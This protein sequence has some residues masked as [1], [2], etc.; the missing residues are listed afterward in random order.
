MNFLEARNAKNHRMAVTVTRKH[1]KRAVARN[2]YRRGLYDALLSFLKVV[3]CQSPVPLSRGR[4][5]QMEHR[6]YG[7]GGAE[8]RGGGL[9]SASVSKP[10][11]ATLDKYSL[12]RVTGAIVKNPSTGEM[13]KG[14]SSNQVPSTKMYL[15]VF[16]LKKGLKLTEKK[17]SDA[18][19]NDA[20]KLFEKA[21]QPQIKN[22]Q[23]PRSL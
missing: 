11:S 13:P 19:V 21:T 12:E 7:N 1:D 4:E 3:D 17:I 6:G 22:G 9:A 23:P 2:R 18:W 16:T 10:P 5:S 14:M 8:K 15:C 20:R